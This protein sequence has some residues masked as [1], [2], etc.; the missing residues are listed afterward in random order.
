MRGLLFILLCGISTLGKTQYI[1]QYPISRG[2]GDQMIHFKNWPEAVRQFS[3]LLE[4]DPEDLELK[5]KLGKS[6]VYADINKG[7]AIA[8]LMDLGE[9]EGNENDFYETLAKAY[10]VNY[11]FDKAKVLYKALGDSALTETKRNEYN[12]FIAQCDISKKMMGSPVKV[13]FENL[14]KNVNSNAPD[15]FPIVTP[16][17]STVVFTTKRDGV[18][19]NLYSYDGYRTSDIY[20]TKHKRN[21]YSKARS[22]G[23]PNTYGNEYTAGRSN[24]GSFIL[25]TV[26]S[27]DEFN[28]IFVSEKGRRSYMPPKEF[29]SEDV[30]GKKDELGST[31]SD[32]GRVMYFASNREGGKGGFDIYYLQRLPNGDWS[33]IRNLGAPI[34]TSGD[35][36]YP[37]FGKGE[38]VL[39]FSSNGHKGMGGLDLFKTDAG[40]RPNT[41]EIPTNLGYPINTPN[42]DKNI[43]FAENERYAYMSKCFDDSFGD[44]DIYR[45]TFLDEK[46]NYTLVSGRV[47]NQ[48]SVAFDVKVTIEVFYEETGNF[49][50]SYIVN[51]MNGQYSAIL[52]PGRYSIEI[53]DVGGYKDYNILL[54]VRG[55]N[56][57][58][59]KTIMDIVL[60]PQ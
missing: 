57:Q 25:Y 2:N 35:E 17:E 46:Y 7:K 5:Y 26:N 37:C 21:K 42:D 51:K 4:E 34:N 60:E 3:A 58:A 20:V 50:G 33:E 23:N 52:S 36:M 45:L 39:Y 27:E 55:K 12:K 24:S 14:G 31:L 11:E 10:F 40:D 53:K 38:N 41:W 59:R 30:N 15:F 18:V 44:L 54:I 9:Y 1:E 32:D 43:S 29:D 22:V 16:D 48:D 49:V 56:D 8:Y 13:S 28:D 6:Y 19:G 47:L